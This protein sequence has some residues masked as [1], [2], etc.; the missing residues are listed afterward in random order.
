MQTLQFQIDIKATKEKVWDIL[1]NDETYPKWTNAFSEG[2][3]AVSD[4]KE[5]SKILFLGPT[6]DGMYSKI[7]KKIPY[8]FMSFSHTGVV[9]NGEEQ[10]QDEETKKWSGSKE[11][12]TLQEKDGIITLKVEV[13]IVESHLDYFNNTFPK[14]LEKV[15]ELAEG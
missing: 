1:W 11:N 9:K 5:G 15:K 3:H 13:D 4:W 6:G 12:Y 14:A 10:P 8:D 7:D 2:S